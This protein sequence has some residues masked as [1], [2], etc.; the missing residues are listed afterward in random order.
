MQ[1]Y[2]LSIVLLLLV[3]DEPII[4][5]NASFND[6]RCDSEGVCPND[7]LLFT[8]AV[9]GSESAFVT[10]VLSPTEE[11]EID[12]KGNNTEINQKFPRGISLGDCNVTDVDGTKGNYIIELVI[13]RASLLNGNITCR[14]ENTDKTSCEAKCLL[15]TGMYM[16]VSG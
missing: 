14:G 15:L 9:N 7:P 4:S 2:P 3:P 6:T 12:C 13:E 10:I 5:V 16:I 8:C 1:S 11:V